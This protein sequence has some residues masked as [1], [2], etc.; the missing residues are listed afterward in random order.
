MKVPWIVVVVV[1]IA[2]PN[3]I[4]FSR[5]LLSVHISD[6]NFCINTWHRQWPHEASQNLN[7]DPLEVPEPYIKP[8]PS[9]MG[10]T[11]EILRGVSGSRRCVLDCPRSGPVCP[12]CA[13][14]A[15]R[16]LHRLRFSCRPPSAPEDLSPSSTL[17]PGLTQQTPQNATSFLILIWWY[18]N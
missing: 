10:F 9:A 8:F 14:C 13:V 18:K 1:P 11:L 6:S 15:I 12:V 7:F 16:P 3:V 17:P 2:M 5:R 4:W